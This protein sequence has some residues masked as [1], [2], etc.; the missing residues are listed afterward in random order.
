MDYYNTLGVTNTATPD[1]IKKAYKKLAMKYHPDRNSGDDT[2]FKKI[3]E[4]YEVLSNPEKRKQYDNPT[5]G[6]TNSHF[7]FDPNDQFYDIFSQVFGQ[8]PRTRNQKSVLKSTVRMS[9]RDAFHG[10]EVNVSCH[11]DANKVHKVTINSPPGIYHGEQ[12]RFDDAI[13]NHVLIVQF[14]IT[15]DSRFERDHDNLYSRHDVSILD[16]I[17]GGKFKFTT[18][19]DKTIEVRVAEKTQPLTRLRIPN[20]GMPMRNNPSQ[21]G[22]QF[23][24]LNPVLP[25]IIP[26]EL[27]TAI[28]NAKEQTK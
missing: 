16:F 13:P 26:N 14:L 6:F 15:P 2:Q 19:D 22:D 21:R 10:A 1:E 27:L 8:R 12:L 7:G 17:A 25:A 9:L 23:I 18:I 24:L 28:Q 5:H 11:V 3:Q 20:A 4:A